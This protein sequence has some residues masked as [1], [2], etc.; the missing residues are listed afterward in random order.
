HHSHSPARPDLDALSLHD[1]LPICAS[2]SAACPSADSS[3]VASASGH[4]P[5]TSPPPIS[6]THAPAVISAVRVR[7]PASRSAPALIARPIADHRRTR[8]GVLLRRRRRRLAARRVSAAEE[9]LALEF[10]A[11]PSP[12]GRGLPGVASPVAGWSLL[13]SATAPGTA[14]SPRPRLGGCPAVARS[15]AVSAASGSTSRSAG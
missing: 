9:D 6:V 8:E 4:I 1:A 10:S 14:D 12:P 13:P 11:P 5:Q 2:C 7:N 15:R 3:L